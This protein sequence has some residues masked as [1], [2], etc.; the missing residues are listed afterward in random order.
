[1]S[2]RQLHTWCDEGFGTHPV[3]SDV[4]PRQ[5]D[6]PWMVMDNT[7]VSQEFGWKPAVSIEQML[8][9]IAEH[10]QQNP[11]WLGRSGL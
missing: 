7:Q 9:Q 2:L 10:A 4:R 6:I 8:G 3:V 11:D 5:Y 1:M